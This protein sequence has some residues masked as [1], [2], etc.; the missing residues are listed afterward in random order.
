M[1]IYVRTN[2][3]WSPSFDF[4][5][6]VCVR[7]W[8]RVCV[9]LAI[10]CDF[11]LFEPD[12]V[13]N[14]LQIKLSQLC[15]LSQRILMCLCL[16]SLL[17]LAVIVACVGCSLLAVCVSFV[18]SG[19]GMLSQFAIIEPNRRHIFVCMC[20]LCCCCC[21][22]LF[23][24]YFLFYVNYVRFLHTTYAYKPFGNPRSL[25]LKQ[26]QCCSCC[27]WCARSNLMPSFY[28]YSYCSHIQRASSNC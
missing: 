18:V 5:L 22:F 4:G 3:C 13:R 7:A 16:C 27:C 28:I 14:I 12:H 25:T 20:A 10:F 26:N 8:V 1:W 2:H 9:R 6:V 24:C 17:T 11:S 19:N 23:F 21:F 15:A